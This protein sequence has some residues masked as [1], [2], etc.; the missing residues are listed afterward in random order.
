MHISAL[1]NHIREISTSRRYNYHHKPMISAHM[2][3]FNYPSSAF[4]DR[5]GKNYE[6]D[7]MSKDLN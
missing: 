4:G 7:Y 5:V 3:S 6:K 1:G 2:S